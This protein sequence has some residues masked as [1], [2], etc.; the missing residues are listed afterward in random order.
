MAGTELL[1]RGYEQILR[2]KL[3]FNRFR[4]EESAP[5]K[6]LEKLRPLLDEL[7]IKWSVTG[8][9]AAFALQHFY[10]GTELILFLDSASEQ[11]VRQLRLLPDAN[12]PITLLRGFGAAAYWKELK[13]TP[14]PTT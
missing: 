7:S 4:S 1:I 9:L 11:T 13:G 5:E 6:A 14:N 2:P 12:G 10:K 8:G 3:L